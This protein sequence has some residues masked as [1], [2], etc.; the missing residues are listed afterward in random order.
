MRLGTTVTVNE[1]PTYVLL[2][3]PASAVGNDL[4]VTIF[5][6]QG[7]APVRATVGWVAHAQKGAEI[8]PDESEE[9]EVGLALAQARHLLQ[10]YGF[11][12]IVIVL[13]HEDL[14]DPA[15]GVLVRC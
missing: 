7:S 2:D 10:R 4:I 15:W 8:G 9:V 5:D 6:W 3:D 1:Q 14:W 12:K 11:Q 13:E